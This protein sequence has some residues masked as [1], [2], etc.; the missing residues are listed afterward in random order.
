MPDEQDKQPQ[1]NWMLIREYY[2]IDDFRFDSCQ[3]HEDHVGRHK[4]YYLPEHYPGVWVR[5]DYQVEE[6]T[7]AK[8][9]FGLT[10]LISEETK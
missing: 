10:V 7:P 9:L 5:G 3:K 6:A 4:S 8:H 2:S 1:C